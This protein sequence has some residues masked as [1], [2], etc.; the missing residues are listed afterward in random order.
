MNNPFK[1]FDE[2]NTLKSLQQPFQVKDIG[3]FIILSSTLVKG[4]DLA[5]AHYTWKYTLTPARVSWTGIG[6]QPTVAVRTSSDEAYNAFSISELN[7]YNGYYSG[8]V[9]LI[10]LPT[11][12]KPRNLPNGTMVA[13]FPI[14]LYNTGELFYMILGNQAITGNCE[15]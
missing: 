10:D 4:S 14:R 6:N 1:K 2:K 7:N 12:I 15:E 8:G 13:A 3:I 9:E 11:P 5:L